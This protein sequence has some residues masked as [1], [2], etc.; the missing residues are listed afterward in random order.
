MYT[1]ANA[2]GSLQR[3]V[4]ELDSEEMQFLAQSCTNELYSIKYK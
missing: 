4:W 1:E 3:A 2:L